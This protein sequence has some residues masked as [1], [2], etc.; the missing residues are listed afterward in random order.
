MRRLWLWCLLGGSACAPKDAAP[1][2]DPAR[3]LG[4][5]HT[6]ATEPVAPPPAQDGGARLLADYLAG[7]RRLPAGDGP[8]FLLGKSPGTCAPLPATR[9]PGF[10]IAYTQVDAGDVERPVLPT[11]HAVGES[12]CEVIWTLLHIGTPQV[13]CRRYTPQV[14]DE[15]YEHLRALRPDDIREEKADEYAAIHRGGVTVYWHWPG[16]A[17]A[18]SDEGSS[19]VHAAD[20]PRFRELVGWVRGAAEPR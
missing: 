13:E 9:P 3:P 17:C 12:E 16:H 6:Q 15:F 20:E 7:K 1:A 5:G 11:W 14:L 2:A 10:H 4:T 18:V 8:S 19:Q